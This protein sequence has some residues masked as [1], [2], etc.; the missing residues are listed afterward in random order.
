[1]KHFYGVLVIYG[2][3]RCS[4]FPMRSLKEAEAILPHLA[5]PETT[6]FVVVSDHP[7]EEV[8]V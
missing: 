7:F 1:M 8:A 5:T 3:D 4:V 2:P 6:K